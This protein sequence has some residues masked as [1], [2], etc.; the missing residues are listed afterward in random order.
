MSEFPGPE[1]ILSRWDEKNYVVLCDSA[2]HGTFCT[3]TSSDMPVFDFDHYSNFTKQDIL[4]DI[5][6][7][8]KEHEIKHIVRLYETCKGIRMILPYTKFKTNNERDEFIDKIPHHDAVYLKYLKQSGLYRARLS[9]KV[10]RVPHS[11]QHI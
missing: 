3:W 10:K 1:C 9:P 7:A 4:N 6:R 2:I 11:F 8:C 5:I